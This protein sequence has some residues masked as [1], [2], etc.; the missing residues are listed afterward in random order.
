LKFL[1]CGDALAVNRFPA[2]L[3]SLAVLATAGCGSVDDRGDAASAA[4]VQ[5][6]GAV[7]N[8]HGADACAILAPDTVSEL[9]ESAGKPCPE[10]ILEEDLSP[11]GS[12]TGAAVYGQWAQVRLT[13]DTVFLGV[14][15]GGWR[16][17]AAG[18]T[19]REALPYDCTLQRG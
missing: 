17:L 11:P 4:A 3:A 15:P 2:I 12:V 8:N 13:D 6:L 9:E 10:A 14:F 1:R 7:A 16:V 5:M 19:A 18:C